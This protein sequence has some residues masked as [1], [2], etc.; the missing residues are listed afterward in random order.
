MIYDC[1]GASAGCKVT[2]RTRSAASSLRRKNPKNPTKRKAV[3]CCA[4]NELIGHNACLTWSK[5]DTSSLN[6]GIVTGAFALVKTGS[7]ASVACALA[8]LD[9]I[10]FICGFC[11]TNCVFGTPLPRCQSA[12][13]FN[14][15]EIVPSVYCVWAWAINNITWATQTSS[16][17]GNGKASEKVFPRY[18]SQ[19]LANR[20]RPDAYVLAELFAT[21][22]PACVKITSYKCR[23]REM[24][25]GSLVTFASNNRQSKHLNICPVKLLCGACWHDL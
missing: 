20:R 7:M 19:N 22:L 8:K 18:N 17:T 14:V 25:S 1:D 12:I 6:K 2:F 5:C 9:I 10:A 3:S 23:S 24:V 4:R 15:L 11:V 13:P 21:C 16:P